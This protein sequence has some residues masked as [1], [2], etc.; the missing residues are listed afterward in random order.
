MSRTA[1][2]I[3]CGSNTGCA[4]FQPVTSCSFADEIRCDASNGSEPLAGQS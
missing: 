3:H 4:G 1:T 2:V